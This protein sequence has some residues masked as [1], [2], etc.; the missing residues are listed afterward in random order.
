MNN[1]KIYSFWF[2]RS[3]HVIYRDIFL[4]FLIGSQSNKFVELTIIEQNYKK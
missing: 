2:R 4:S 1:K 3:F